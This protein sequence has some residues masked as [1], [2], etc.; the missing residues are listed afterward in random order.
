MPGRLLEK[1]TQ[2]LQEANEELRR[3]VARHVRVLGL[4]RSSEQRYR[5]L[6]DH[7]QDGI[8]LID[9]DTLEIRQANLRASQMLGY[10]QDEMVGMKLGAFYP[11]EERAALEALT[12]EVLRQGSREGILGFHLLCKDGARVP[13]E[14]HTTRMEI[15][16][17]RQQLIIVR[18]IT[19]RKAAE[20]ALLDKERDRQRAEEA[21]QESE[22]RY[23]G[24]TEISFEGIATAEQQRIVEANE[25]FA[26]L[27][28]FD[29]GELADRA[30]LSLFAPESQEQANQKIVSGH[31]RSFEVIG[32]RKDGSRFPAEMASRQIRH[33]GRQAMGLAVRDLSERKR[34][35]QVR[36]KQ[37]QQLQQTQRME[38][39][40]VLAGGIAHDF[41]NLLMGVLGKADL[42][43]L[44][45][46][47]DNPMRGQL[48]G[49][50]TAAIR[51]AELTQQIL[52]YSGKG[53]YVI[54]QIHLPSVVRET[55][56]LLEVNLPRKITLR[57]ELDDE[58]PRIEADATQIRQVILNL[59]T[60]AAEAMAGSGGAITLRAGTR[61]L[62][63]L[64]LSDYIHG[65]Q[66]SAGVYVFL[67][68]ADT[69][70]GIPPEIRAKIF[71]PFF[72]T[73]SL[74]RGLGLSAVLG[75]V[76][77][78]AGAIGVESEP[79][80]GSCLRILFPPA[81]EGSPAPTPPDA[82]PAD[83]R[84]GTILLV[85]DEPTIR[86]VGQA[87]LERLGYRVVV[88][89][90]GEEALALLASHAGGFDVIVLD[91]SM[92]DKDGKET[93]LE[94]QRQRLEIPVILSSGFG[95]QDIY[96]QLGESRPTSFLQKPYDIQQLAA[97][98]GRTLAGRGKAT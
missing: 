45:L 26:K 95:E 71:E 48:Q 34:V 47:A 24:L 55:I 37:E 28:G 31:A 92:P 46:P 10:T 20:Q 76:R 62:T 80:Q 91:V 75:I 98:L 54:E 79:G 29:R 30:I 93:F 18:D 21:L 74:C 13:V 60:N 81:A 85:D 12:D 97:L 4:L 59:I 38:S 90:G 41:N 61:R 39:L 23:R 36:L 63:H 88:A 83:A 27:F 16:G 43:L 52:A 17:Q 32:Q 40:G 3:Q 96:G 42:V 67:E 82:E 44:D 49:V 84:T 19:A 77:G 33:H 35:E 2:E 64:E 68:V 25:A 15:G 66:R 51:L 57:C 53:K 1:R 58:L 94:I 7:A 72:S 89:A 14:I 69:G 78:H 86:S 70:S 50:K 6:F 87:M 11:P 65:D 8:G 73:K 5:L 22:E 9:P 56:Q